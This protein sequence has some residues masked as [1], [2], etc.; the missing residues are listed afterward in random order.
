M[1]W[2]GRKRRD[3][4]NDDI[5]EE[6]GYH[7]SRIQAE[8]EK[9][10][11]DADEARA[12]ARDRFGDP[13]LIRAQ[14]VDA[15]LASPVDGLARDVR[16]AWRSIWRDRL[17]S[18]A[19]TLCLG[20]GIG[21]VVTVFA[22]VDAVMLHDVTARQPE[23]LVR[24]S[25]VS[26][27]IWREVRDSGIFD[28][29]AAGGQCAS[30]VR[31]RQGDQLRPIVANC[32]SANFWDA[33]GG[34]A[35]FGRLWTG[36]ETRLES[37]PRV[38]V[39]GHR[40]SR[41]IGTDRE[42]LGQ[43][44][45]LNDVPYTV[46]GVMSPTY[47]A[48]QGYGVTPDVFIPFNLDL[49]PQALDRSAP[50]RDRFWPV[51]RLR[52]GATI[53]S[54]RQQLVPMLDEAQAS[55]LR[56]TPASGL[57]K[58]ASEGFDRAVVIVASVI[59]SIAILFMAIACSNAA[60]MLLARSTKRIPQHQV[61]RALGAT[62]AHLVRQQV[63]ESSMLGLLGAGTGVLVCAAS[64]RLASAVEIPVQDVMLSMA[65]SPNLGTIAICAAL[66]AGST[67]VTGFWPILQIRRAGLAGMSVRAINGEPK[68]RRWLLAI[69]VCLST[70]LLFVTQLA[71]QNTRVIG[72]QSPGF[73]VERAAWVDVVFDRRLPPAERTATR[74]R[75]RQA[76]EQHPDVESVSWA[77]YLPFQAAYGE[78]ILRSQSG[79]SAIE[80]KAIEQ[81]V[82][83]GY[84][85]TLGIGVLDG[86]EF[87]DRDI[88]QPSESSIAVIN[89]TLA[90]R[91]FGSQSAVGLTLWRHV[92]G[93]P[94]VPIHVV[95]VSAD[96]P[97][98]VPGETPPPLIHTLASTSSS[99]V[100]RT[101]HNA[102]TAITELSRSIDAA[103]PGAAGGGYAFSDRVAKAS[104]PARALAVL[105]TFFGVGGVLLTT[106]ALLGLVSYNVARRRREIALRLALGST[107]KQIVTLLVGSHLWPVAAG[108]M[109]GSVFAI[110]LAWRYA[111]LV[112]NSLSPFDL[113]GAVGVIATMLTLSI[114]VVVA[115]VRRPSLTSPSDILTAE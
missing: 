54:T 85:H 113:V 49:H 3:D 36:N 14:T 76:L 10:G 96:T 51:A 80:V 59:G 29:V 61:C 102:S 4:P 45:V 31:W 115:C 69:Q 47:R 5:A 71:W 56:L 46:I 44:L 16:Y 60:G 63:L 50:A 32:L 77:W 48:I 114:I 110:G 100:V 95:G 72:A 97:F 87:V 38:I 52:P 8:L 64:A 57:A 25:S 35:A 18:V 75:I 11:T 90:R 42:V 13:S 106:T 93:R 7:Y 55:R 109:A 70:V 1:A 27:P 68:A 28:E 99:F 86:R 81:G 101:R 98:R 12:A 37:N 65:F 23:R 108:S 89:S 17:T 6:I 40:F 78:P 22:L 33:I 15:V 26:Y 67:A 62:S 107:P 79:E 39:L 21:V 43:T 104:F 91:V 34:T 41:R 19:V 94:P 88:L 73:E 2:F 84:F 105:F 111:D 58:Y 92:D 74:G 24:F 112:A 30:P 82:G 9:D 66:G 53:E 83:P 20:L 103:A